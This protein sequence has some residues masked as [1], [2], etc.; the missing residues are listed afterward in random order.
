[1]YRVGIDLGGTNIVV[2]IVDEN[3]NIVLKKSI[4]T[5]ARRSAE[6][7]VKS[8]A[9]LMFNVIEESGVSISNLK[10]FGIGLPGIVDSVNGVVLSAANLG[11]YNVNIVALL[12][13]ET[14]INFLVENDANAAVYGEYFAGAGKE[15]KDFIEITL[16][17]GIGCGIIINGKIFTGHGFSGG[18]IGHI[19]IDIKGEQCVC[20]NVGCFENYASATALISQT[21]KAMTLDRNSMMWDISKNLESV[22]GRTAFLAARKGDQTALKVVDEYAGFLAVGIMAIMRLFSPQKICIGGG[23]SNE[24]DFL[25]DRV[26]QY[27]NTHNNDKDMTQNSQIC[28]SR[29]K[30]D[31]GI[32]GAAFLDRVM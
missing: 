15:T 6:N 12:K 18:E 19:T 5:N 25:I 30:N 4:Q 31:A 14:G 26:V 16:G 1:M 29:L 22:D 3:F 21:K 24:G 27:I 9:D 2:G 13:K 17:T 28:V 10:S 11:F 23:I 7:I 8:I 20:G 32:I